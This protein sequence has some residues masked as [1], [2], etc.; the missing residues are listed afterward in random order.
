MTRPLAFAILLTV[1]I[2]SLGAQEIGVDA[3]ASRTS[4]FPGDRFDYEITL[5]VAPGVRLALQDF[6]PGSVSFEPFVLIDRTLRQE[7]LEDGLTRYRI[8]YR[9]ANYEIGDGQLEIPG[10]AFRYESSSTESDGGPS[11]R[12]MLVPPF[13]VS[14]KSTLNGPVGESWI[15][16]SLPPPQPLATPYWLLALGGAGLVLSCFPLLNWAWRVRPQPPAGRQRPRRREF[17][18]RWAATLSGIGGEG[19]VK[20]DYESIN[21]L[22]RDYYLHF[23]ELEAQGLTGRELAAQL[24]TSGNLAVT[25]RALLQ[26]LEHAEQCRYGPDDEKRWKSVLGEDVEAL[27]KVVV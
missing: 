9:L 13:P 10:V 27:K 12:E 2:P 11:T 6:D 8:V 17:A 24:E 16:E 18:R 14:V 5:R 20:Q 25:D 19:D 21:Q 23:R 3:T 15:R 7:M 22:I 4:L 1:L 26:A